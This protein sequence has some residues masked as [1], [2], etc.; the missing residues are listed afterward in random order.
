M[1]YKL[2]YIIFKIFKTVIEL[3]PEKINFS[4]ASFLG[5]ISYYLVK[6]R[7]Q[8]ALANLKL[9]FPEKTEA[10]RE[11]IAKKSFIV[12][13]KGFLST[14]WFD[15]YLKKPQ[16]IKIVGIENLDEAIEK[17]KGVMVAM[18]HMGNME[19][20]L[21]MAQHYNVVSVAKKQRNPYIDKFITESRKKMNMTIL[22][23][24]KTTTRELLKYISPDNIIALFSDHR[25]KGAE[26]EFFGEN[27]VAP[28]GAISLALKYDMP[29]LLAYNVLHDNNTCTSYISEEISL[30]K[31]DSFKHDVQYNTQLL[32]N[33]MEKIITQYPEQWMWFHD[34]WKLY[35]KLY[36]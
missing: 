6:K 8:I 26:V 10:Q 36:V 25:D 28:T 19:A 12:M 14:L 13:A 15:S 16:N 7:R 4:F 5:K 27:T 18:I 33:K 2:Q 20:S 1:K 23:K 3:L 34:R 17:K 35:K 32:I 24:S 22:K 9:A 30:I 31:T 29:I 21:K 11:K